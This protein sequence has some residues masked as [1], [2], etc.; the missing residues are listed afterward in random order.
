MNRVVH[1]MPPGVSCRRLLAK[2]YAPPVSGWFRWFPK[3]VSSVSR[4]G[5]RDHGLPRRAGEISGQAEPRLQHWGYFPGD[6]MV[7]TGT[8]GSGVGVRDH[9]AR[10]RPNPA[11]GRRSGRCNRPPIGR[12]PPGIDRRRWWRDQ[13][14]VAPSMTPIVGGSRRQ[15]SGGSSS[16]QATMSWRRSVDFSIRLGILQVQAPNASRRV[17]VWRQERAVG[18]G[19]F[20]VKWPDRA[21]KSLV[22]RP[23]L[24]CAKPQE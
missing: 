24:R 11:P 15:S 18:T 21:S 12:R 3:M 2:N 23:L 13:G 6:I 10:W 20:D 22:L 4:I 17:G 8:K 1:V 5:F 9:R 7:A 16:G 19:G 14:P